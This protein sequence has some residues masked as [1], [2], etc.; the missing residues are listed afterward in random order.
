MHALHPRCLAWQLMRS[1]GF[2]SHTP[3]RQAGRENIRKRLPK[4]LSKL[5]AWH[6]CPQPTGSKEPPTTTTHGFRPRLTS[7]KR[8][9][10][11]TNSPL[12]C[13]VR[14]LRQHERHDASWELPLRLTGT[15]LPLKTLPRALCDG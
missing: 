12:L 3:S 6:V 8:S 1:G 11:F 4:S 2:E 14:S 10:R 7:S 5:A 15:D 9:N 13:S